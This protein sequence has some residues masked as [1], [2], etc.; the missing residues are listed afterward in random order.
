MKAKQMKVHNWTGKGKSHLKLTLQDPLGLNFAELQGPTK[1]VPPKPSQIEH[2]W[3]IKT[4]GRN[5]KK[6]NPTNT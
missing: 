1:L 6:K 4:K 2:L 3:T 5:I